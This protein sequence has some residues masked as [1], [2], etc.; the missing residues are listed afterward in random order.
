MNGRKVIEKVKID[1]KMF[2]STSEVGHELVM[3]KPA[4]LY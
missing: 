2:Y 4:A 1:G 3:E